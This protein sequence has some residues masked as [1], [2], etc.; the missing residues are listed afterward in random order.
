MPRIKNRDLLPTAV[1]YRLTEIFDPTDGTYKFRDNDGNAVF[2]INPETGTITFGSPITFDTAIS[3][4]G[5]IT[6][7][8]LVRGLWPEIEYVLAA[9]TNDGF[10]TGNDSYEF[11]GPAANQYITVGLN[12]SEI[13]TDV[14][15][16]FFE[17]VM[18]PDTGTALMT[19]LY[20]V[21]AAAAV[22]GSEITSSTSGG[23]VRTRS[24]AITLAAGLN[25]YAVQMK[26]A[27]AANYPSMG[28]SSI[29]IRLKDL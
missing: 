6:F 26:R 21:T 29:I 15:E 12:G 24:S 8:G 3:F 7:N 19:Q 16:V 9:E 10:Y 14:F 2:T 20:N 23:W 17:T 27:A 4:T 22:A 18:G 25:E 11:T 5:A 1:K 13:D 28:K